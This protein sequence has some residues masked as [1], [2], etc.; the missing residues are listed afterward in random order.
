MLKTYFNYFNKNKNNS[1][2]TKQTNKETC[3]FIT[4]VSLDCYQ[5][6]TI[7]TCACFILLN[8]IFWDQNETR[9]SCRT[10][11][12]IK[13]QLETLFIMVCAATILAQQ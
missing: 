13:T 10:T 11:I 2:K 8:S 12:I 9:P 1:N 4:A 7:L 3:N 5:I 6:R